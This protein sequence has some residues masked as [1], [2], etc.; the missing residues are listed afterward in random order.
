MQTVR[1]RNGQAFVGLCASLTRGNL[2]EQAQ[3][4]ADA[5]VQ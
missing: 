3:D 4:I 5:Y 1:R 2:D